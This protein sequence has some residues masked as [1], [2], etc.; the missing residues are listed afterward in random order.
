MLRER[1]PDLITF[2]G[3]SIVRARGFVQI[4]DLMCPDG[5]RVKLKGFTI[6]GDGGL[7][8]I[9]RTDANRSECGALIWL[10]LLTGSERRRHFFAAD[11]EY[12]ELVAWEEHGA[13]LTEIWHYLGV[14]FHRAPLRR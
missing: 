8:C 3:R 11:V 12:R 6:R 10:L 4:E 9:H 13:T 14:D 2:R 5:H 7:T 1:G